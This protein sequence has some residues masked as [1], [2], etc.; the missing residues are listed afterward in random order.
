MPKISIIT[1]VYIDIPAK[2]NWLDEMIQSVISQSMTNW[3]MILINDK[4]PLSFGPVRMKYANDNR[5]R[6]LENANNKGPAITRNTAV[7]LAESDCILPVD[8]DDLLANSEVLEYMYDAWVVD[9]TKIIYGNL[10]LYT[11]SKPGVFSR[12]KVIE[13]GQY[14][15]ELAMNLG[16]IMPVTAMHS[17]ECHYQSGGWKNEFEVGLEDVEYWISAGERGFCGKKIPHTTLI[18]RRQE[19]SR[20]YKLKHVNREF[21]AMQNKIKAMHAPIYRGE[22]PMAC[23]GKSAS[24]TPTLDP[25]V[26]S[27][28]NMDKKVKHI[29]ELSG[30]DEKD[31]EWVAYRG[32]KKGSVGRILIRGAAH[33][34]SEYPILGNGH[35]FQIHKLH[36]SQFEARQKLGFEVNQPDPRQQPEPEPEP[37]LQPMQSQPQAVKLSEPELSTLVSLDKV[38]VETREV[39]IVEAIIEPNSPDSY[40]DTMITQDVIMPTDYFN[41]QAQASLHVSN[42]EL[43]DKLTKTLGD[44][45]YTVEKL[46]KVTPQKLSSLPGI[47]VKRA[48]T[49]IAKAKEL[50]KQE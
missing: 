16:G 9:K 20:A 26:L 30:Y 8:A 13:L 47:G 48:N 14:T 34:P 41:R 46:T 50:I 40:N 21:R 17:K 43:S 15:F 12:G 25:V 27:Q 36:K 5:L 1:P 7:A 33:L 6:W 31:L 10:Q 39:K 22:F 28:Q 3:E 2:V 4:S 19:E 23:C 38:G 37:R 49:I 11:Q 29:T 35:V 45:G 18:Y 42:L 32:P 44:A 24:N